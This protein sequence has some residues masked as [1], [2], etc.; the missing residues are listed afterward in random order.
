MIATDCSI[1]TVSPSD[2]RRAVD[3]IVRAFCAD[4]AARWLYPDLDQY[5]AGFPEFVRAFG[6]R[7]VEHGTAYAV[8]GFRGA[9]LWL[10]PGVHPNEE[11]L[12][13]LLRRTIPERDQEKAF[14]VFEQMASY[15]PEEPH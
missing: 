7:A 10:P 3:V 12:T 4:P 13:A 15:H 8:D 1:I 5:L 11:A 9:A 14:S 2:E 6:G